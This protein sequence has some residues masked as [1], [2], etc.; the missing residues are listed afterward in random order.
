MSE[1]K[2]HV[3]INVMGN[4]E[5]GYTKERVNDENVGGFGNLREEEVVD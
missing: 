3:K 1:V 4:N 5:M 2:G